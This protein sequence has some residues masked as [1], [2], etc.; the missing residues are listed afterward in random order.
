MG[1]LRAALVNNW[2]LKLLSLGLALALWSSVHQAATVEIDVS[3]PLELRNVPAGMQVAAQTATRVTLGLR[4]PE[5]LLSRMSYEELAVVAD[6]EGFAVGHHRV[7]LSAEVPPG[8]EV[9]RIIPSQVRLE[10]A[11]P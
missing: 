6:L 4:G 2:W 9:V 10:L 3:V 1:W 11:G 5:S 7:D 8:V